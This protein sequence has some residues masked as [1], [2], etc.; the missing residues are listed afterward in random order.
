MK[1]S[2][3]ASRFA[4]AILTRDSD[5]LKRLCEDDPKITLFCLDSAMRGFVLGVRPPVFEAQL[6]EDPKLRGRVDWL[7]EQDLLLRRRLGWSQR[8]GDL[9]V[10][11]AAY[12]A[13]DLALA[14]GAG[15]SKAAGMP[16][17]NGLVIHLIDDALRHG[18]PEHRKHLA[19]VWRANNV[20]SVEI[21]G[22][23]FLYLGVGDAN[24]E[25]TLEAI[26]RPASAETRSRLEDARRELAAGASNRSAALR[27]AGEAVR[28]AFGA[29]LFHHLQQVLFDTTLYR[30]KVHPA[31]T[32]MV[33]PKDRQLGQLT[34]RV[35][36]ILT[37]NFD[38]LLETAIRE[39]GQEF[40]VHLSRAGVPG[41]LRLGVPFGH[42]DRP[43]AVGIYHVHGFT[44]APRGAFFA[45]GVDDVDLVFSEAQYRA[46]YGA[47]ESWTKL[48]QAALFG[49][50]PVLFI[51]S[52]LQDDESVAQLSKAHRQRP[53]WF[54]Y[55]V[56]P[57]PKGMRDRKG[58]L[59]GEELEQLAAPYRKLG[60]HVLWISDWDE[61]AEILD[62]I[63][64]PPLE[65]AATLEATQHGIRFPRHLLNAG[66][67]PSAALDLG[68]FLAQNGEGCAAKSAFERVIA[69]GQPELAA[70]A[71]RNLGAL[72]LDARDLAGAAAAFLE[73]VNCGDPEQSPRAAVDLGGLLAATGDLEQANVAFQR[74]IDSGHPVWGPE[75]RKRREGLPAKRAQSA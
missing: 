3:S 61:I 23:A 74:A 62:S 72:L 35:F 44:P 59:T 48:V 4:R 40:T 19:E 28:D 41:E 13:G 46:Q 56:L 39:S 66:A 52:S 29:R 65:E 49:N 34:P 50:A 45:A 9:T 12:R 47:E 51:G 71:K 55:A 69:S 31:I 67:D 36:A 32:R 10:L 64:E 8:G 14:V 20:K 58:S 6:E 53:G 42:P 16:D 26:L 17:W 38:D 75:A 33:R 43:S 68:I 73:V 25:K 21:E 7:L 15:I 22:H 2:S 70:K 1:A 30:T 54:R 5:E 11:R 37:Y 27:Q 60:L 57:L 24:W 18:T 63:S